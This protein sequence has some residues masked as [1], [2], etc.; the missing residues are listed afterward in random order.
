MSVPH[1]SCES[2]IQ[3]LKREEIFANQYKDLEHL[4]TNMEGFLEND[5]NQQRLHSALG[6]GSPEEV[7]QQAK[8]VDSTIEFR[9]ETME[10]F[11]D[12]EKA[13]KAMLGKRT[14]APSPSPDLI[15]G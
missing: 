10:F 13:S 14:Q 7:E 1:A 2:F 6:C 12:G 3:T 4:R 5:Y 15:P 9:S 8:H 11:Q